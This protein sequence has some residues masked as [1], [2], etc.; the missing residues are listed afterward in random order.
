MLQDT[1]P[2]MMIL[3]DR[4]RIGR[5]QTWPALSSLLPPG[6]WSLPDS[7]RG[8]RWFT[9]KKSLGASHHPVSVNNWVNWSRE[10]DREA[11]YLKA[12]K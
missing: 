5:N 6:E 1:R 4:T 7:P 11:N 2:A 3:E 8:T 10:R 12:H 9:P